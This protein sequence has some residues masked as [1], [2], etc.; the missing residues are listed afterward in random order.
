MFA[1]TGVPNP[2][3]GFFVPC[4]KN[5][6][7][8]DGWEPGLEGYDD[9]TDPDGTPGGGL[10]REDITPQVL[11]AV[12][13]MNEKERWITVKGTPVKIEPGESKK[14]ACERFVDKK[15]DRPRK[16][17]KIKRKQRGK[18]KVPDE[19][20]ATIVENLK[21]RNPP[22]GTV[23]H[24]RGASHDYTV[25]VESEDYFVVINKERLP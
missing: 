10:P 15:L 7:T 4:H 6:K 25:Y 23:Q 1:P 21:L 12:R 11:E 2:F 8:L 16:A 18:I 13:A 19:D 9:D 22:V 5:K 3:Y 14:D 20:M 24:A 17:G